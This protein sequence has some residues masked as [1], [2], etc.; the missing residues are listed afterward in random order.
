M[1]FTVTYREKG[2]AKAE[3][4]IAAA[5][6]AECFA[7]CK[8]R[9]IAPL[10][11]RAGRS[12]APAASSNRRGLCLAAT[13]LC[14][15]VIGGGMWWWFSG[16]ASATSRPAVERPA[17]VHGGTRS[18]KPQRPAGRGRVFR[19]QGAAKVA[20]NA[21][22]PEIGSADVFLEPKIRGRLIEM[23]PPPG[24]IFTNAFENFIADIL[25]AKPGERFLEVEVGDWFDEAFME[26]LKS[27]TDV[28]PDDSE[29]VAAT[30]RA[31]AEAR[32][33]IAEHVRAGGSPRDVVL[34]ARAELNKIADYRDQLQEGFH[35][36]LL[37]EDDPEV[38]RMYVT[39]AND[40]LKEYGALPLDAPDDNESMAELIRDYR[41]LDETNRIHEQAEKERK[42]KENLK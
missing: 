34:E 7:Q 10:G 1:T 30:K 16:G 18:E 32:A 19:A 8:A 13:V 15:A 39:E 23:S 27:P 28:L 21:V 26:A 3:V 41:E 5:S 37:Q 29:S 11:V 40:M 38:L 6:R 22:P 42:E 25:T 33:S 9:G 12:G 4:E 20:T 24:M 36:L 17:A 2:G 35:G 14:A 31:V